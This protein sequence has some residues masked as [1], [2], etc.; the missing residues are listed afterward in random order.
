MASKLTD[1]RFEYALRLGDN[2]LILGQRLGEWCGHAPELELDIAITNFSLDFIGQARNFLKYAGKIEGKGRDEDALAFH[3]DVLDFKNCLLVEQPNGHWGDTIARQFLFSV[4]EHLLFD[5][6]KESK[7]EQFYAIAEK[8]LKET[9]Y[10]MRFA[11]DWVRKLGDG[12][13]ESHDKIQDSFENIWRFTDEL[14]EMDAVD[15]ALLDVGIGVDL[16]ALRGPWDELVNR[17]LKEATLER[18]EDQATITG[19]RKGHHTEHL[20]HLLAEM[21]YLQRTYPEARW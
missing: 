16:S 7:D 14:F 18:P 13:E 17:V 21:Q 19:G 3:R 1:E 8:S 20:G 11:G 4:F 2:A 5:K 10:H 12:T 9:A 6:L 15:E